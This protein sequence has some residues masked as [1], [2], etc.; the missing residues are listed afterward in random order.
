MFFSVSVLSELSARKSVTVQV[1][2]KF[3]VTKWLVCALE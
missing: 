1:P 2:S 3:C